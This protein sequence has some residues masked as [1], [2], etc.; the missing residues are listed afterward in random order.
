MADTHDHGLFV[1]GHWTT[2]TGAQHFETRNPANGRL[3]GRFVSATPSDVS[4]AISAAAAAFPAWRDTP[5]PKRG[6]ILLHVAEHYRTHKEAIGRVVSEEMGKV[7]PE[8]R[9]DIQEAID[10]V[11]YMAGEGRRMFGETVPSELRQK[12][13]MTIRQAKGVVACITP[14]NFPT[15]IPNWKIA[16]ALVCGNTVV[17]K[18][19][20]NTALCAV[21][22]VKAY[23]A[24][25]VPPGVLNLV[26]GSGRVA[27]NALVEDPR[28]RT[29]SFTGG[30]ETGRDVYVR[31]AQ[32]LAMVHLELGGKNPVLVM[33]DADL[34]LAL[35]GVLFG[36]FGT[37]GQR[38]TATSRLILHTAIYDKFLTMLLDRLKR[39][40]VG[41]P[42][43]PKV[44][45]GP[46]ASKDQEQKILE[47]IAI[48]RSEGATLRCGGVK[49]TGGIYDQ[50]FFIAPTIFETTHGSRISKEEI[51]GPVLSVMRAKDY[52]EAVHIANDVTYGLSSSIYTRDVNRA[53][54]AIHELEAGIT[55]VN[56]PTIGAEVQLPFG[57]IKSTGNGGRE[58][59]S[60][61][62]EEFTE[63]K[64]VFVD[65]SSRLQKAQI[66][67]A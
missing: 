45:M 14:W 48:G 52:E 28:I 59:G 2:P 54:R 39:F 15:A 58:A 9:G 64:T 23:E 34:P 20:S 31:G 3:L 25:G 36:A 67:P 33:E 17:F 29:I 63:V 65:F 56:A 11:E 27:G 62:I 13:C 60:A 21:E 53:F 24:A 26:T 57:G 35:E 41:D 55:Y 61:A 66:D 22:V 44:E 32:R 16:A 19:A 6:E 1:N 30:V 38:C 46:V 18:P 51:F 50:G 5:A 40:P 4:S 49:L 12:F 37:S 47:Y 43:D 7:L 42:L 8:G 10:F